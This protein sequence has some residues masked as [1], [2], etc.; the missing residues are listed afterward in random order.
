MLL[1][2]AQGKSCLHGERQEPG[3]SFPV[4]EIGSLALSHT[5]PALGQ[6]IT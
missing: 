1:S 6:S 5:V 2:R 3:L 4:E